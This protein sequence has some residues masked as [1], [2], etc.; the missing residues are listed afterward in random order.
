MGTKLGKSDILVPFMTD[1]A[2]VV[3]VELGKSVGIVIVGTIVVSLPLIDGAGIMDGTGERDCIVV[4]TTAD[5]SLL[6]P[7]V[8]SGVS[9][10]PPVTGVLVGLTCPNGTVVTFA[11]PSGTAEI[12]GRIVVGTVGDTTIAG[13]FVFLLVGAVGICIDGSAMEGGSFTVGESTT[14]CGTVV[15][16]GAGVMA[17]RVGG[18]SSCRSKIRSCTSSSVSDHMKRCTDVYHDD[19]CCGSRRC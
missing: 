3:V 18:S 14:G 4:G 1:G 15:N 10:T 17:L 5:G 7:P 8:E 11:P 13:A 9:V 12:V 2:S 6:D 16:T 19:D